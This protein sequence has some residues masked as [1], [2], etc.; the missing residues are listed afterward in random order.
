MSVSKY[1][2]YFCHLACHTNAIILN[3]IERVSR[4][5][6]GLTYSTKQAIFWVSRERASFASVV[7]SSKD[8][9]LIEK[10]EFGDLKRAWSSGQ[11][12]GASSSDR[13]YLP[14]SS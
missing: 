11:F 10:E 8:V 1:E 12:S 2:I 13:D 5:M 6:R 14:R 3:K 4:F 7:S 9:E